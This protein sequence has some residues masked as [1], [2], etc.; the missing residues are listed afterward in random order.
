[1]EY[2]DDYVEML[3]A[4]SLLKAYLPAEKSKRDCF[5]LYARV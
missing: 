1:L 5:K 4:V 2:C 3:F